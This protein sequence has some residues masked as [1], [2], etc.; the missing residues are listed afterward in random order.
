VNLTGDPTAWSR[1]PDPALVRSRRESCLVLDVRG[2]RVRPTAPRSAAPPA[3]IP[4]ASSTPPDCPRPGTRVERLSSQ[5]PTGNPAP[6]RRPPRRGAHHQDFPTTASSQWPCPAVGPVSRVVASKRGRVG[7]SERRSPFGRR[8]AAASRSS[9][10]VL[11][12]VCA[13]QRAEVHAALDVWGYR[14]TP[15]ASTTPERRLAGLGRPAPRRAL[16]G[17]QGGI[18]SRAARSRD[19]PARLRPRALLEHRRRSSRGSTRRASRRLSFTVSGDQCC[20]P[21]RGCFAPVRG[22]ARLQTA[23]MRCPRRPQVLDEADVAQDE[24]AGPPGR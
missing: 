3:Y 2:G 15:S 16:V 17:Q 13:L 23:T 14:P 5:E 24:S 18:D 1:R 11:R 6:T 8:Q 19:S 9:R 12:D 20:W 7:R 4:K 10:R 21:R 22:R